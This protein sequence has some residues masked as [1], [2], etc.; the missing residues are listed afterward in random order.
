MRSSLT[1]LRTAFTPLRYVAVAYLIIL[2]VAAIAA[3]TFGHDPISQNIAD[4][5]S[6]PGAAGHLLGTDQ[7]G[8][9]T[10]ARILYGARTE[11]VIAFGTSAFA[12]ILGTTLGMIG[13]YFRR[14]A[15]FVTMR[16]V[17]DVLLAFPPI[18]LALLIVS[19]YGPGT[20]TLIVVMGILFSPTFA[21]LA[22]GQTLSAK[23]AEYV[24]AAHAY[25][26]SNL[27]RV[28]GVI[29]PN[30]M[31]VLIVQFSLIMAS[32]ILLESGLSYLGLGVVPPTPSWGAMVADGQRYM[33]IDLNLILIPSFAI[34]A[35]IL[36]FSVLGDTLR[37]WLDPRGR[38]RKNV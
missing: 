31:A 16:V 1:R 27:R 24:D 29:L 3:P 34:V 12:A 2:V 5:M 30:I 32:S 23:N 15:E 19:I 8:R 13:G 20:I 4:S 21:R 18:V 36:C 25:G 17:T 38:R 26:A 35:T 14:Y 28:F 7:L 33:A 10:L 22:Y 6:R 37:E 9:D 11:L